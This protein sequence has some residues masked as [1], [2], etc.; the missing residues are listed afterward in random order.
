MGTVRFFGAVLGAA[1]LGLA[2]FSAPSSA[3]TLHGVCTPTCGEAMIGG[4]A[5]HPTGNLDNFGFIHDPANK[6]K[7]DFYLEVLVPN[8]PGQD[9]LNFMID[10][11]NTANTS[12]GSVLKGEWDSGKLASFLGYDASPKGP[13][14]AFLGATQVYAGSA[15]GYF[16]YEFQFGSVNFK[17]GQPSFSADFTVPKG[18]VVLA[19]L[20]TCKDGSCDWTATAQS[21]ALFVTPEPASIALLGAGLLGLRWRKSKR[22]T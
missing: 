10:G 21:A 2:A 22:P 9:A 17:T 7:G 11:T 6:G 5:I 1:V 18:T 13:L 8:T 3:G 15:T 12:V 16:V 14:D 19:Y 20:R 4:D